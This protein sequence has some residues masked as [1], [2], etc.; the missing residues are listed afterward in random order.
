MATIISQKI[1][2]IRK[3]HQCFACLRRFPTGTIMR[4]QVNDYDG[5][6]CAYSCQT[7]DKLMGDYNETFFDDADNVY[8]EGCVSEAMSSIG[9]TT[10]EELLEKLKE[11][12]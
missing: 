3:Q 1:V 5:W 11:N 10:P 7:C 6:C 9:A 12:K 4:S 2:T 8:P